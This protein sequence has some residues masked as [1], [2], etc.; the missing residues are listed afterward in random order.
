MKSIGFFTAMVM[1]F[2]YAPLK[3]KS[4]SEIK[5]DIFLDILLTNQLY[6]DRIFD[7]TALYNTQ[8]N[9][10]SLIQII[11]IDSTTSYGLI[12]VEV[13]LEHLHLRFSQ[14]PIFQFTYFRINRTFLKLDGFQVSN[15]LEMDIS[16]LTWSLQH[17]F[18]KSLFR[19]IRRHILSQSTKI[20]RF[21]RVSILRDV[22]LDEGCIIDNKPIIVPN[23]VGVSTIIAA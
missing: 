10:D 5:K 23:C 2:S 14:N 17:H 6:H 8:A 22:H 21:L 19:K 7:A 4:I 1:M 18:E 20:R 11:S 12:E 16:F 15:I 3:A 9:Y 13:S